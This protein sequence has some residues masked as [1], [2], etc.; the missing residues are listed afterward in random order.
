MTPAYVIRTTTANSKA[1][2]SSVS[3][4]RLD[5]HAEYPRKI[6]RGA[7]N[8]SILHTSSARDGEIAMATSKTRPWWPRAHDALSCSPVGREAGRTNHRGRRRIRSAVK[9]LW[10]SLANNFALGSQS[11]NQKS[12]AGSEFARFVARPSRVSRKE[13]LRSGVLDAE[14]SITSGRVPARQHAAEGASKAQRDG[15]LAVRFLAT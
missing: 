12:G 7:P 5:R 10:G 15:E 14:L 2:L 9:S 6:S 4:S 1:L 8:S 3:S 11:T 13:M